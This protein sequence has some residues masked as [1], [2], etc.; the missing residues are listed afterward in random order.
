MDIRISRIT[1]LSVI[2]S[3][4]FI[5]LLTC[6]CSVNGAAEAGYSRS[7]EKNHVQ[8]VRL[9]MFSDTQDK[10]K[11]N[12]NEIRK[13]IAEK[14]GVEVVE[15]WLIG[16]TSQ[17]V[18]DGFLQTKNLTDFVYFRERLDEFYKAG[19]LVAWDSYIEKYPNIKRL[20]TDKEW[21]AFRQSDGHIYSVNIPDGQVWNGGK[22]AEDGLCNT[23]GFAVTTCCKDPDTAFKFINDILSEE[24]MD[25]R[26]WGIKDVDY[27]VNADGTYYRTQEM[28]DKWNDEEYRIKHVCQY[29]M[30]P[31]SLTSA[32]NSKGRKD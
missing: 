13:L 19:L 31:G 27:L 23:A 6:S 32:N 9:S 5:L 25:L 28:I 15:V 22:T 2:I 10:E 24:I 7:S 11:S 18:Y 21:D 8:P 26:F 16:Q 1:K 29:S 30:M 14:T 4:F 17:N 12:D 20:Y 3:A